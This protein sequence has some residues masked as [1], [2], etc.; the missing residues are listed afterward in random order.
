MLIGYYSIDIRAKHRNAG[1]RLLGVLFCVY[2][3]V[4]MYVYTEQC[5]LLMPPPSVMGEVAILF[6][7]L[8]T[9]FQL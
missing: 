1:G 6:S 2:V 3:C 5:L 4:C 7:S 8:P 9:N